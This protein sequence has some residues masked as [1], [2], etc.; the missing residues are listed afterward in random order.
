MMGK[1]WDSGCYRLGVSCC[2]AWPSAL[3]VS[4]DASMGAAASTRAGVL[5][6]L[7]R[8]NFASWLPCLTEQLLF[9]AEDFDRQQEAFSLPT[10]LPSGPHAH[11][12]ELIQK[13]T[14]TPTASSVFMDVPHRVVKLPKR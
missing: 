1:Q 3:V 12:V 5:S 4:A 6:L 10:H 13:T 2:A 14:A 11:A 9:F 7:G 8:S